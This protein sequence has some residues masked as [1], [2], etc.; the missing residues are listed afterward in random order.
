MK[1][2]LITYLFIIQGFVVFSQLPYIPDLTS[3]SVDPLTGKVT[4]RW[5]PY[6]SSA[7][8]IDG[9]IIMEYKG[10]GG[11]N[12]IFVANPNA[13]SYTFDYPD[14]TK[15]SV[16]FFV[17]SYKNSTSK[18]DPDRSTYKSIHRTIFTTLS[19]DNC[20]SEITVSWTKYLGWGSS[21]SYYRVYL[22]QGGGFA[23]V[24]GNLTA[25]DSSFVF[26]GAQ[27]KQNYCF[28]VE[29]ERNDGIKVTSNLACLQ[30]D[31]PTLPSFIKS[32]LNMFISTSTKVDLLFDLDFSSPL[33]KYQLLSS[34]SP[35][36]PFISDTIYSNIQSTPLLVI[37]DIKTFAP[38]YFRLDALNSCNYGLMSSNLA[39]AIVPIASLKPNA[40]NLEWNAY[41]GWE[42]GVDYYRIMRAFGSEPVQQVN[43][44]SGTLTEFTDDVSGLSGQNKTGNVC[45]YVEAYSNAD[46]AGNI[47][48]SRSAYAC[49][50]L[51]ENVFVPNAFTPNGDGQNDEFKPSFAFIPA[52]YHLIIYNRYGF[53]VFETSDPLKGWNGR[54]PGGNKAP[55]GSYV[56]FIS[57]SSGE[58]KPIE[59]KGTLSLI[60]P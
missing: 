55:E 1:K 41:I 4:M 42:N 36:G 48:S 49:V 8:N 18:P 52:Q 26:K 3:V 47:H 56:Y 28:Y 6:P 58:G 50:D 54:T 32:N 19:I 2:L 60:Y 27:G 5:V 22:Q 40:V 35:N 14:V 59:K 11:I 9:Y 34:G 7:A 44:V 13:T 43:T 33:R 10:Q 57:F 23:D 16:R 17:V 24:S 21:L 39:T 51:S 46:I 25:T 31:L 15:G 37:N 45:Y 53:Q 30:T 12:D 38:R 20:K 29:A